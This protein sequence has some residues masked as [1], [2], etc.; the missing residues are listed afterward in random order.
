M[1]D[2]ITKNGPVDLGGPNCPETKAD[3]TGV[4]DSFPTPP[5]IPTVDR[6]TGAV[7]TVRMEDVGQIDGWENSTEPLEGHEWNNGP[8]FP[9]PNKRPSLRYFGDDLRS[10]ISSR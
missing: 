4:Q 6:Q 9:R 1:I 5:P 7:N 2:K 3:I 10:T 8:D